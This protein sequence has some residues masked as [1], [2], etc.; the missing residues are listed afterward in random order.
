MPTIPR[1]AI[2]EYTRGI[3]AASQSAQDGITEALLGIDWDASVEEI[4]DQIIE[5][6]SGVCETATD[7]AATIAAEYYDASREF[8]IGERMNVVA[9]SNRKPEATNASVRA[10]VQKLVDGKPP[11][12]VIQLCRERA[13]YEVKKAAAECIKANAARDK[14]KPR[15]A[16]VPDGAETCAF[17]IMLASRGPVYLSADRAGEGNHFHSDCDCRIVPVWGSRYQRT[18]AGGVIRR[19][20]TQIEGYDPDA[21]FDEYLARMEDPDFQ[22]KMRA[23]ADRAHMRHGRMS[24]KSSRLN[25]EIANGDGLTTYHDIHEVTAAI[26][27]ASTYEELFEVITT[28]NEEMS[29]YGLS[30]KQVEQ[31]Q[32]LCNSMRNK[33]LAAGK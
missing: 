20:G 19:G 14:R 7:N 1:S 9:V 25:W 30:K 31:L 6:M 13:D 24:S 32:K 17:C 27:N 16:R 22:A 29:M 11:E 33:L 2:N 3:N 8:A 15:Y 28:I 21:L 4:R 26:R 12:S 5:V 18:E 23:S 10:F